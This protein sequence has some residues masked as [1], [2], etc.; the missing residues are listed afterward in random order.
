MTFEELQ[1]A[2]YNFSDSDFAL[3]LIDDGEC[4]VL[5]DWDKLGCV[6]IYRTALT[7]YQIEEMLAA[8]CKNNPDEPEIEGL[9]RIFKEFS[10]QELIVNMFEEIK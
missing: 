3:K 4:R 9:Y 1:K 5:I 8:W 7:A 10:R 2:C 6:S